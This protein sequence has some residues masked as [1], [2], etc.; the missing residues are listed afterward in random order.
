MNFIKFLKNMISESRKWSVISPELM[1]NETD[2]N[3]KIYG[4]IY[5][6]SDILNCEILEDG[7]SIGT[8]GIGKAI[9]GGILFGGVGAVVGGLTA[10][11]KQKDYCT[12]LEVKVTLNN[13]KYPCAI[14]K[15]INKKT[16]K[17]SK[18]YEK[19]FSQAQKYLSTFQ[20]MMNNK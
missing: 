4:K 20:V 19:A 10:A 8:A 6:Y 5:S 11:R 18:E 12:R 15:C 2:K 7:T 1:I 17:S 13:I 16:Q 14:F 3:I 9:A